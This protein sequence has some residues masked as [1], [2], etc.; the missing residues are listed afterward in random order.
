MPLVSVM[1]AATLSVLVPAVA[2]VDKSSC[3]R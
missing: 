3:R 2:A 1:A